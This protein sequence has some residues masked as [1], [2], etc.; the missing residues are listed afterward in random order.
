MAARSKH[1]TAEQMA[2]AQ[3]EISVSE[4]FA[5]NR[6]LLGFDSPRKALLTTIKEAVD[7]S[8][9]ACEEAGI[10]PDLLIELHQLE[11]DRF[12][13]VVEDNGPG[14]VKAQIPNIFGK[15]L[16]GSKFHSRR[17]S[18]GQ[19]GIGI[20][21]AGLYGQMTTG[22]GPTIISKVKRGK[23]HRFQIQLDSTKNKPVITKDEELAEWHLK[24]GTR[25]EI[26]LEA[27][28]Q[29]GQRSVDDYLKQ[30]AVSNPHAQIT[31]LRPNADE[32]R[33][34]ERAVKQVPERAEEI[35]PH[36]YGV[37]L[38]ELM[39]ML[40]A[41]KSRWLSGFLQEEF[42]RVGPKVAKTIIKEAGLSERSYPTRCARE[43][44]DSLYRAIQKSKISAPPTT[45][46]SPIGEDRIREGLMKETDADFYAVATRP[47][48]VY[49]GNPFQ[50]EVGIA[51]SKP[52][53]D[54]LDVDQKGRIT[55]SK[56]KRG[57]F[58][59]ENLLGNA[60]DPVRLLRFANRVPLLSQQ[61]GCGFT[62]A[63]IQTSW[64]NYGLS[65]SR[66]ALPV[67]SAVVLIHM[68]SVWVPF[69]SEAKEAIAPYPEI[70]KEVKLALQEAG[71]KLG[72]HIRKNKK[73]ASEF[74]KRNY[75]EKYL[76]HVGIGLQEILGISDEDREEV[77]DQLQ[78][79]METN[80]KI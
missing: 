75:I 1:L 26:N 43:E 7:N 72:V 58:D 33:V 51:W 61:S 39:K 45:C 66:G 42:C 31:Y 24:H 47:P 74:Q 64:K 18:R 30:T 9:D 44:A 77:V 12:R 49:R 59:T 79:A 4:F 36:P 57:T 19:Q 14:I 54:R 48:A 20:S 62:K 32:P 29:R 80:R 46:L 41:T 37:E 17:Q 67:G 27:T 16:Y 69:T 71:R 52:G 8:L 56:K 50:I 22:R 21:A 38:G 35:K 76:P 25:V 78:E 11:E 73:V 34:Y 55:K 3:K 53:E 5:K 70:L 2:K 10:L 28:Y 13:I 23:T 15:L 6:H 63:M 40:R 65:Q 68:A 60:D